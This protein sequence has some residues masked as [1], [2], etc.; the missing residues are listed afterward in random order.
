MMVKNEEKLL[1]RCLESIKNHVDEIVIVDTGSTDD[2]VT[3]AESFGAKIHRHPWERHFS[4]HRNQSL[5]YATG[6]WLMIIDADEE[7][8]PLGDLSLHQALQTG[9]DIDS[10]MI[11]V[12]CSSPTGI[13]Q[14]N[15]VRFFRNH[16]GFHYQGRVHNY[17]VGI[18]KSLFLDGVRFFHH[19][20]NLGRDMDERKFKRTTELLKLDILDNPQNPRPHHFLSTS[21]MSQ[22]MYALAS[23]SAE[24]AIHLF[25]KTKLVPHNYLWSLYIAAASCHALGEDEKAEALA[26]KAIVFFPEHL[27]SHFVLCSI[28]MK[29]D[30]RVLFEKHRDAYLTIHGAVQANPSK[31]GEMVHN[32][33]PVEWFV[34]LWAG[35]MAL[36]ADKTSEADEHFQL[37]RKGAG[38]DIRFFRELARI[39]KSKGRG[40][41]AEN[42]ELNLAICLLETGE[43]EGAG[44]IAQNIIGRSSVP[45]VA[46]LRVSGL[47]HYH[48]GN[49]TAAITAFEKMIEFDP[50]QVEPYAHIA[51]MA[52]DNMDFEACIA[53]CDQLL[54]ILGL[55]RN[56]VLNS[57]TELGGQFFGIAEALVETS[58]LG[59]AR[60]C[61]E[62][63]RSL[64]RMRA[65]V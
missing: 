46:A 52:V 31:S 55:D 11:S 20:Y 65:S 59:P 48:M 32:S 25:E 47:A 23:E 12:E 51:K 54:R 30:N 49:L 62:T 33:L 27:D 61:V 37:S 5:D 2:T 7:L 64:V 1:P 21:Y 9:E 43:Y 29:K 8:L 44:D 17:L 39:F 15:S 16:R 56:V 34:H 26:Y 6:D 58:E 41:D 63:G 57:L 38:S 13:I 14:A 53:A 24:R 36:M 42:A 60:L 50:D 19:G 3:I 10:V 18:R 35:V 45:P 28:Y 4:R 40:S 22:K